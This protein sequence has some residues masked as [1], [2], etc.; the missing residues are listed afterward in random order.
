ML[1]AWEGETPKPAVETRWVPW[2]EAAIQ[3]IAACNALLTK[4]RNHLRGTQ[5]KAHSKK[6]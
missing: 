1:K 3:R 4:E 2:L 5:V 6:I